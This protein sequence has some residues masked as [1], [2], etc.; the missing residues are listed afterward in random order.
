MTINPPDALVA[1]RS[2]PRRWRAL[3]ASAAGNDGASDLLERSGAERLAGQ[4]ADVLEATAER[5]RP[6]F[7]STG[8]AG[9]VLDRIEAAAE[10]LAKGMDAV[11]A[12]EWRG[13]NIDALS[14]GIE[15]VAAL[16]RQAQKAI[17]EARAR[18]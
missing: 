3:F 8:R 17:E 13:Q 2:F 4:A 12:D 11:A 6:G 5:V 9:D 16:L 7:P 18:R 1:A 10:H 15:Q 14:S